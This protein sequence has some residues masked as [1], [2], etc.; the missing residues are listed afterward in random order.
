[1]CDGRLR[2]GALRG[3]S[4]SRPDTICQ[5][6]GIRNVCVSQIVAKWPQLGGNII[7]EQ[8]RIESN[9]VSAVYLAVAMT[10]NVFVVNSC[11]IGVNAA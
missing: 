1:M 4:M 5:F 11:D 2:G 10:R 3:E 7:K 8:L 6:Y 9:I